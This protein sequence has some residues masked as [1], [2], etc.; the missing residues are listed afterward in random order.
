MV[1]AGFTF[2]RCPRIVFGAGSFQ[3]LGVIAGNLGRKALLVTGASSLQASGRLAALLEDLERR[4]IQHVHLAVQGEPSPEL[5]DTVVREHRGLGIEFVLA[6][7]GGS[8]VDAGKAVSAMLPLGAPV[9]DYLEGMGNATHTGVK[10]PFIAVP[11]TAGTGSEATNNAV[12]S[13]TGPGGFKRSLRHENFYPDVAL[14]DPELALSCPS[15]VSASCGM[16]AFTQLLE[17]YVSTRAAPL[18]DALAWSGMERVR[19]TLLAVCGERGGDVEARTGMAYAALASGM[20]LANAGLGVVHGFASAIGSL[21]AIPHGVVCGTL[22]AE[23]TRANISCLERMGAKGEEALE[24]YALAGAMLSGRL[25]GDVLE[26]CVILLDTLDAWTEEL[27]LPRLRDYGIKESDI[28]A[29]LDETSPKANP[30]ALS[31]MELADILSRR[32]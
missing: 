32:I 21:F 22:L 20:T 11:T 26:G 15:A 1:M 14:V 5:V 28:G 23:A 9:M 2:G 13:R 17:S 6:V 3:E 27:R 16:D 10:L 18:T 8:A 29:I 19:D 25:D 7:G 31:R 24:K 12:L 4:S 30:A